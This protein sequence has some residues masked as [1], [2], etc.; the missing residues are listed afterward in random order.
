MRHSYFVRVF[1]SSL[2]ILVVVIAGSVVSLRFFLMDN[3]YD[4]IK[5]QDEEILFQIQRHIDGGMVAMRRIALSVTVNSGFTPFDLSEN[6]GK[7]IEAIRTLRNYALVSSGISLLGIAYAHSEYALSDKGSLTKNFFPRFSLPPYGELAAAENLERGFVITG[8]MVIF[9]FPYPDESNVQG[10]I[11]IQYPQ[12]AFYNEFI[13][14]FLENWRYL[15]IRGDKRDAVLFSNIGIPAAQAS[16]TRYVSPPTGYSYEIAT[17]LSYYEG[18][19]NQFQLRL[20]MVIAGLFCIGFMLNVLI[21]RFNVLPLQKLIGKFGP[22]DSVADFNTIETILSEQQIAR[23]R[24]ARDTVLLKLMEGGFNSMEDL[25]REG[26]NAGLDF[27]GDYF[28]FVIVHDPA[29]HGIISDQTGGRDKA[30]FYRQFERSGENDIWVYSGDVP[31]FSEDFILEF[32]AAAYPENPVTVAA[33][34]VSDNTALAAQYFLE[35]LSA[36]NHRLVRG[37]GSVILFGDLPEADKIDNEKMNEL[38]RAFAQTLEKGRGDDNAP[39]AAAANRVFNFCRQYSLSSARYIIWRFLYIINGMR[40][41]HSVP[42]QQLAELDTMD[43]LIAFVKN[44]LDAASALLGTAGNSNAEL[45]ERVKCYAENNFSDQM[46]S[47]QT[48]SE[49]LGFSVGHLSRVFKQQTGITVASCIQDLRIREA[50]RLLKFTGVP[51]KN[52]VVR[53][54]YMDHSSFSRSFKNQTGISPQEYRT[55]HQVKE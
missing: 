24:T 53:I 2:I 21:A 49:S 19:F 14:V 1:F 20:V 50:C 10:V 27:S 25:H 34:S 41:I 11:F 26:K 22:P 48:I 51:V 15:A 47:L 39:V 29:S 5:K 17:P 36:M 55:I 12:E 46:L 31:A 37:K 33:G 3:V 23:S 13:K 43:S 38:L 7:A 44:M 32:R 28:A 6:P 9:L 42:V 54:G 30:V 45:A 35:A 52:I 8:D 4:E 18:I 16:I 40:L